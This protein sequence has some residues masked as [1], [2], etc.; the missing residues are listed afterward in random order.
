MKISTILIAAVIAVT[1]TSEAFANPSE[2]ASENRGQNLSHI[3]GVPIEVG[4]HSKY[5]YDYKKFNIAVNPFG[6]IVDSYS[7]SASVALNSH[8]AIRAAYTVASSDNSYRNFTEF[9]YRTSGYSQ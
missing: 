6:L 7:V 5:Y 9:P 8:L 4:Q 3:N 2:V 1:A